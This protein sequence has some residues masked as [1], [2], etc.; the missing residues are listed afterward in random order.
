MSR[1][2]SLDREKFFSF[3]LPGVF[4]GG[5]FKVLPQD[6]WEM[7]LISLGF[8]LLGWVLFRKAWL[9]FFSTSS[10]KESP[11]SLEKGYYQREVPKIIDTS[12]II[13]GRLLDLVRI[14]FLE[15]PIWIPEFVIKELK[16]LSS[17]SENIKRARGR[18]GLEILNKLQK[19]KRKVPIR[20]VYKDY[21]EIR[22][23]DL[24]LVRLADEVKGKLLT[25][26]Y[27]LN[28]VA[29]LYGI[30]VLNI[31]SLAMYSKPA[32]L[33]GEELDVQILREG[34]EEKQGI[35]YL[36]DGTMVV[37]E[38]GEELI[39]KKVRVSV[40]RL[41]ETPRGRIVFSKIVQPAEST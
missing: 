31:H 20:V 25:I 14:G 15:G 18:R 34:K 27:N 26:D 39:G 4:A 3:F 12:S 5:F 41:L 32:I 33:P 37:I 9:F 30:E 13:D 2:I 24:K 7:R 16:L 23:V 38:E 11:V 19:L 17:S 40:V 35:G 21:P 1:N 28:Q 10:S 8:F 36:E 29:Q 22:E 6:S